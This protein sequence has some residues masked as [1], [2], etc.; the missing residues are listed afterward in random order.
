MIRNEVRLL[1]ILFL[2]MGVFVLIWFLFE[3]FVSVFYL[4]LLCIK[5]VFY[6]VYVVIKLFYF[7]NFFINFII[8][9]VRMLDYRDVVLEIF[10]RCK[11][12]YVVYCEIYFL[13]DC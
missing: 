4:C 12:G 10:L 2:I 8:Y 1:K 5:E 9:C 7:S 11:C 3:V 13:V 6:V